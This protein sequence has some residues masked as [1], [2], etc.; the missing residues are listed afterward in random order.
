MA[1]KYQNKYRISSARLKN[2]DYSRDGAYFITICTKDRKHFFG[3][4]INEEMYLSDLGLIAHKYWMEIPQHFPFVKLGVMVIM[5]NHM[6]GI[7]I[8]D[9]A[10]NNVNN[11][12]NRRDAIHRI[13]LEDKSL[14]GIAECEGE[15]GY[16]INPVCTDN[17]SK[18]NADN[19]SIDNKSKNNTNKI[20]GGVT[21][22]NNPMLSDSLAKVIRWYKGRVSFE[23]RKIH[24]KFSWQ[25]LFYDN[26]IRNEKSFNRIQEYIIN[27]PK[28]WAKDKF[29]K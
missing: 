27:N 17:I 28:N 24:P 20:P 22:N 9:N 6:H 13:S 15:A 19:K 21:G 12:V 2:W 14:D 8:I 18:N 23:S 5:Q 25:S 11:N 1:D 26:I 4:I 16:A 10:K 3:K 7:I 29:R